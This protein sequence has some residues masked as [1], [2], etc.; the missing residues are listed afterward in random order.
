LT[1]LDR[2]R[3][4]IAEP[5][6]PRLIDRIAELWADGRSMRTIASSLGIGRGGL[7]DRERRR[8][9]AAERA[10]PSREETKQYRLEYDRQRYRRNRLSA[11]RRVAEAEAEATVAA[12]LAVKAPDGRATCFAARLRLR[13]APQGLYCKSQLDCRVAYCARMKSLGDDASKE[14][15]QLRAFQ[16]VVSLYRA[17]HP[18]A[19]VDTAKAA[20]LAAIKEAAP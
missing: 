9:S 3:P 11:V 18:D 16:G 5:P 14:E 2:Q 6:P 1:L 13:G 17:D 15:F 7:I 10:A 20:V 8:N 4:V 19:D 12:K